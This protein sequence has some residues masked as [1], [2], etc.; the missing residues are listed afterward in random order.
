MWQSWYLGIRVTCG[1][2][3]IEGRKSV[4]LRKKHHVGP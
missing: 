3:A 1:D 4:L 2:V